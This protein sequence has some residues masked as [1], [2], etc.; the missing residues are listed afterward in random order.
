[1]AHSYHTKVPYRAIMH[2]ILHYTNPG[3]LIL[4]GFS[5]TG[6]VHVHMRNDTVSHSLCCCM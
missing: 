1:M 3:D 4:D 2:Y 5:G 6:S